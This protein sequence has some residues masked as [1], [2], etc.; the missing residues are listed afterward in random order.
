MKQPEFKT[1]KTNEPFMMMNKKAVSQLISGVDSLSSLPEIT[2]QALEVINKK[3]LSSGCLIQLIRSDPS[4][5]ADVLKAANSAFFGRSLEICS[6]E[7]ALSVLGANKIQ[8]MIS[9]KIV[10]NRVFQLHENREGLNALW[11]HSCL[12]GIASEYIARDLGMPEEELFLCGIL[13]DI[14][15]FLIFMIKPEWSVIEDY[16]GSD[17]CE[18]E[19]HQIGISHEE[20]G[21][22]L[23]KKW[24]FPERLVHCVRF[25]H[26]P[27]DV[28]TKYDYPLVVHLADILTYSV[29]FNSPP[30][31]EEN[32]INRIIP[33]DRLTRLYSNTG[34]QF[35]SNYIS[36]YQSLLRNEKKNLEQMLSVTS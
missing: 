4:L 25:H 13:H 23:L 32:I 20:L 28:V 2:G 15:K 11:L 6:I 19:Q 7:H 24:M 5:A 36:R 14:G 18:D 16:S 26:S 22:M 30:V 34:I 8:N 3:G 35:T 21:M 12:C 1:G 31:T 9:S 10:F 29:Q 27:V 17:E 33:I